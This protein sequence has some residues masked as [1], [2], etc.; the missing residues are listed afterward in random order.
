MCSTPYG[1]NGIFTG[2]RFRSTAVGDS[3]QRLTASMV[4]SHKD[5]RCQ[6]QSIIGAQRLTASMVFSRRPLKPV[7]RKGSWRDIQGRSTKIHLTSIIYPKAI[8]LKL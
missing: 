6:I 4:F 1:I 5:S 8:E 2:G 7:L 3:A